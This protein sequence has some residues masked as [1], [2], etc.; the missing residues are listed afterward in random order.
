MKNYI[1][2]D[3][4]NFVH[5]LVHVLRA[6]K[7]ISGRDELE[8]IHVASLLADMVEDKCTVNYY[9]TRIQ[10]PAESSSLHETVEKMRNWNAKWTPY[11]ANQGVKIIKAGI[12]KARNSKRCSHCQKRTEILLEK[13]VDVR[14]GVDIVALGLKGATLYVFSSDSDIIAAIKSA[15]KHG[16]KVIYVAIEGSIN[17]GLSKS[18]D[19]RVVI[20]KSQIYEAYSKVNA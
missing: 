1:L 15:R 12:L 10:V 14:L 13:G 11:L 17:H 8:R 7:L 3:G 20:K 18:T 5:G 9:T 19:G 6:K 4:E 2:V 16:A